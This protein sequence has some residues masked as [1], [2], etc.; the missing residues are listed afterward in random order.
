VLRVSASKVAAFEAPANRAD[1]TGTRLRALLTPP[2]D[3][4]YTFSIDA[5]DVGWLMLSTN[6]NPANK[7]RVA[8][9]QAGCCGPGASEPI[10]LLAG[11][12]YY[13]EAIAKESTGEDYL[14]ISWIGPKVTPRQTNVSEYLTSVVAPGAWDAFPPTG[15][16]ATMELWDQ[17]PGARLVDIPDGTPSDSVLQLFAFEAPPNQADFHGRRL[18]ALLVPPSSG[19]YMFWIDADDEGVL[20]LSPDDDPANKRRIAT[21]QAGCC[22]PG[23]SALIPLVEGQRYYIEA[24]AKE[25][26]GEDYLSITWQG[27]R[28]TP[29]IVI[30]DRYLVSV[31]PGGSWS[32][33]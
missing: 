11:Q 8:T 7:R 18:E 25:L 27:P 20:L 30:A 15:V 12:R 22:G 19:D 24:I 5:D 17:R 13:I 4:D 9:D 31:E 2:A 6:E 33:G 1:Y 29:R 21:D 14:A 3:G 10:P 28:V 23:Q 26:D 32:A 16:G